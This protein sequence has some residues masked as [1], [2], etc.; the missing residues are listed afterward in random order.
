MILKRRFI[1]MRSRFLELNA[2]DNSINVFWCV[3]NDR[4]KSALFPDSGSLV[5]V[6]F[7]LC[8]LLGVALFI[9]VVQTNFWPIH[10][11]RQLYIGA[12]GIT[13]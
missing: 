5:G 2:Q 9:R 1:G 3:L 12:E 7:W 4:N 8:F 13:G 6:L 11:G 10:C